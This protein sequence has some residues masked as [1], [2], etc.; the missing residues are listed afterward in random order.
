[1]AFWGCCC[2]G[3]HCAWHRGQGVLL[4]QEGKCSLGTMLSNWSLSLKEA[5]EEGMDGCLWEVKTSHPSERLHGVTSCTIH[6]FQKL[7]FPC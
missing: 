1:M 3:R 7:Q 6:P 4:G 5:P 2:P